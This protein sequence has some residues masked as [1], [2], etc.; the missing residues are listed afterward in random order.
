MIHRHYN[1][2]PVDLPFPD[3][4]P[5]DAIVYQKDVYLEPPVL[6]QFLGRFEGDADSP[7]LDNSD[8][9]TTPTVV[10][11]DI[12]TTIR[13]EAALRSAAGGMR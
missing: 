4:D 12:N 11:R 7:A 13:T 9:S 8:S 2:S 5:D 10:I 3:A 1:G 6:E